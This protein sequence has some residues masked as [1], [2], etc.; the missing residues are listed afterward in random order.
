[1]RRLP[2]RA[3]S[4][5]AMP[6]FSAVLLAGGESKRMG[7]DKAMLGAPDPKFL[8]WQWQ[9]RTLEQLQPEEIFWSGRE[10]LGLPKTIRIVLDTV[11]KAGPLAG[12]SACLNL[13]RTD[14]LLVLAVDLPQMNA[15][16]LKS[17][18]AQCT[19]TSGVVTQRGDCF[20]PLAAIY[21]KSL[22]ALAQQHLHQG[23]Y[24][25]QDFVR[26]AVKQNLVGALPLKECDAPLFKNLN[27][28]ADL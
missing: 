12:I 1:M 6:S 19:S 7:K 15:A 9:L 8:L 24:A 5:I 26:E 21:P 22:A 27:S 18:M 10:R 3:A 2:W 14:L 4:F 20:E 17:L 16:Y 11:E 25:L 13:L 23:R 28:P